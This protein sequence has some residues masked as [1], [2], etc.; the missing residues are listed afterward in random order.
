MH[1]SKRNGLAAATAG[2][3]LIGAVVAAAATGTNAQAQA[4]GAAAR[5]L[6]LVEKGGGLKIIDNPPKARHQFDISAGD[7][8]IVTR[9]ITTAHGGGVGSLRLV[10]IATG[11]T[12]QQ[13]TGSEVLAGGTLEL[14]G[15]SAPSPSTVVAVVGGTGRYTGAH[16]SSVSTDRKTNHDIAD[17]TITLLP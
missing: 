12:T 10:C 8:I 1:A 4:A 17:Q 6:R 15:V 5:T 3:A 13:C 14:A 11:A 7:I 9:D 16:G 2:A